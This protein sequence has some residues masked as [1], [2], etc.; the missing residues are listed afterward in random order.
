MNKVQ[1]SNVFAYILPFSLLLVFNLVVGI[2]AG[3]LNKRSVGNYI[4]VSAAVALLPLSTLPGPIMP[5]TGRILEKL[6]CSIA[7]PRLLH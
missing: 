1:R 4:I 3:G 7:T 6:L 2:A 5:F